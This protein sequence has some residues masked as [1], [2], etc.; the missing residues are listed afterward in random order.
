ME[1]ASSKTLEVQHLE[2]EHE[3]LKSAAEMAFND[4]DTADFYIL[5]LNDQI[6]ERRRHL[7]ELEKQSYG[8][9]FLFILKFNNHIKLN[10]WLI[11]VVML[12]CGHA[13]KEC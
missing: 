6:H 8:L 4:Q 10:M 12:G 7:T 5:Q 2:E 3:L 1:E 9:P 13:P 11:I